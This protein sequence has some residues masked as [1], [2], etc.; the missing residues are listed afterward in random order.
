MSDIRLTPR[1]ISGSAVGV[2]L[3]FAMIYG[4]SRFQEP[5][6]WWHLRVG[7]TIR[8]THQ[9]VWTDHSAAF[10]DGSYVATQWLPEAVASWLYAHVG[11]GGILWL[12]AAALIALTTLVYAACRQ[13]A[14]RLPAALVAALTLLGAGGG[15]NP[16]PQLV[17]F[18]LFA[19]TLYAWCGMARDF[20][21]R[22]W[23]VAVFW[24]WGCSHGL[25]VFGLL[26]G[27]SVLVAMAVDPSVKVSSRQV[28]K[29]GA[30][31]ATCIAALAVTPLGPRLLTTP[32]DVAG[33]AS[34]IAEEWKATPLN[35]VFSLTTVGM[36]VLCAVLW[37]RRPQQR[38]WWQIALL[39]LAAG[40]ALWMW[41]LVPLGAITAAPLLAGAFQDYM[42]SAARERFSRGERSG[43]VIACT[44]LLAVAAL[45][46]A[47]PRGVSASRYPLGMSAIDAELSQLP[48]HTVVLDDFGI[49]GWLLWQH[50]DLVPVADLRGEIYDHQYLSNYRD[51]LLAK[52]GWEGFVE[53][54]GARVALLDKDSA[55]A[56]ALEH[57]SQWAVIRTTSEFVLLRSD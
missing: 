45:V 56:D 30:L 5:D 9:L 24:L 7:D 46:C 43:L 33:N 6:L 8:A 49:S 25:W 28:A 36:V 31:W 50:P 37:V 2:V 19:V 22:W 40:L 12:R 4:L 53:R 41:R 14:A 20:R 52:P 47:G 39:A 21:P 3:L 54:T 1:H 35:N 15:L 48:S 55:L 27:G 34:M 26:L 17:S 51:A 44:V 29:L 11:T 57:R 42:P 23:L 38:A 32:F 13:F 10:A 18:V 16:R